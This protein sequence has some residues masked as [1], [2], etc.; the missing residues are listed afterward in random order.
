MTLSERITTAPGTAA[1]VNDEGR[2]RGGSGGGG[3]GEPR[4][5]QNV[6][7][8]LDRDFHL[9]AHFLADNL[10]ATTD[11]ARVAKLPREHPAAR[12]LLAQHT[13]DALKGVTHLLVTVPG[14]A[15]WHGALR[16]LTVTRETL[17]VT[18]EPV[19]TVPTSWLPSPP[20]S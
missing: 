2:V 14:G 8:I 18:W 5:H 11:G 19:Y 15:T 1:L 4:P 6:A 17:T 9:R 16:D 10:T 13:A 20:S 12:W 7:R 3:G